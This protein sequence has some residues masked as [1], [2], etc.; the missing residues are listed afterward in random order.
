MS[1][2][3]I[4]IHDAKIFTEK[5][6]FRGSLRIEGDL[7][8]EIFKGEVP[9][10]VLNSNTVI[11]ASDLW[12]LP[13]VIDTHVHFREPGLTQKA[14][15]YTESKAAV[16]GGVTSF[17]EMPNTV[18]Q[19]TTLALWEEKNRLASEKSLANYA[20]YLGATNENREEIKKA[21][22]KRVPGVKVF[23]GASTGSMQVDDKEFLQWLFAESPLLLMAHCEDTNIIQRNIEAYKAR[24]GDNI[25]ISNH[26]LIRSGEACYKSTATAVE[27]AL[28]YKTRLHIAH[29]STAHE[30][31]LFD[32]GK[33]LTGKQITAEGCVHY[34]WFDNR[35]Y[36]K[37]GA[38]IKCN[39]SIKTEADK[40][41]LI[42]AL[43]TNKLDTV[44]TDHAP[45]LLT[46]KAGGCLQAASGLPLVQH[47]L[48]IMLELA[49]NGQF[50]VEK[51]LEK[52]CYAPANLFKIQKRGFVRKGYYA[53]LVLVNPHYPWTV[54]TDNIVSK[55][56]WSPFEEQEFHARVTHT[57]VNGKLVY[58][59]G[60]F[61]E[62]RNGNFLQFN[63]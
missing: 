16:A 63:G 34:F 39:P 20:F 18:P 12:L 50:S 11:D 43:T 15:L 8:A 27:M 61:D 32:A 31:A 14:D 17:I 55:C 52:M 26:Y 1:K 46:E 24:F 25:P 47:S 53:D 59:N 7:I 54:G 56:G 40:K 48:P 60:I 23:L 3:G 36:E 5:N 33:P 38:R 29:V 9:E 19:T 28:K 4:L 6:T 13:G 51:V 58:N 22:P 2:K 41:A 37:Y 62:S 57:F 30:L 44:A 35:D 21:D 49:R 42:Q 45:H 10:S